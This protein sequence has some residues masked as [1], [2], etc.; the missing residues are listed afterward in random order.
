M[1]D[2]ARLDD[3]G[4]AI[5]DAADHALGPKSVPLHT[6]G[7]DAR[8]T[9]I[10][11]RAVEETMRVLGAIRGTARFASE[12]IEY[13]G[14]L[15]PKGTFL[16]TVTSAANRDPEAFE[17]LVELERKREAGLPV[18]RFDAGGVEGGDLEGQEGGEPAAVAPADHVHGP[19]CD[20][21]HRPDLRVLVLAGGLSLVLW[22][23][24][25]RRRRRG[26]LPAPRRTLQR[27]RIPVAPARRD[28]P[29]ARTPALRGQPLRLPVRA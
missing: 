18:N 8:Q 25:G 19:D 20:H 12:D 16:A 11:P 23:L 24:L 5:D 14:V 10:A 13:R 4:S 2:H 17:A 26:E 9:M 6:T 22:V 1:P 27:H 15:F 28:D 21:D 3:L 7:I 29:M